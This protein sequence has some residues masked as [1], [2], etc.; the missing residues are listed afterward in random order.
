MNEFPLTPP[1]E[2]PKD[3]AEK[4]ER[5]VDL[6]TPTLPDKVRIRPPQEEDE[7]E[8]LSGH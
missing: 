4:K 7:S 5:V 6:P 8:D 2:D 1:A 3:P